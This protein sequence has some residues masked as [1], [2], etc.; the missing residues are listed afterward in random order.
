[1]K[2]GLGAIGKGN[3]TLP[4]MEMPDPFGGR[5]MAEKHER[6]IH[7]FKFWQMQPVPHFDGSGNI[8]DGPI[9][10]INPE[11]ISEK[12]ALLIDGFE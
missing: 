6:D 4:K 9:K 7:S 3:I 2:N 10:M 11:K 5:T 12:S 1:M 8:T